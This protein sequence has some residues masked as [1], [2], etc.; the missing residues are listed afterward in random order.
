[1]EFTDQNNCSNRSTRFHS[2]DEC[3]FN[4]K[5]KR[6]CS[7]ERKWDGFVTKTAL[8]VRILRRRRESESRLASEKQMFA[9]AL[10][11]ISLLVLLVRTHRRNV[12][13][14]CMHV[15]R[16]PIRFVEKLTRAKL[17]RQVSKV[18]GIAP[19]RFVEI[20]DIDEI[21]PSTTSCVAIM[22]SIG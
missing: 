17:R 9:L 15:Y 2:C 6:H 8:M 14:L 3:H 1:M 16:L 18:R 19:G 22:H 13:V 11:Y 20:K 7:W 21:E 4:S 10:N 12:W 5:Q